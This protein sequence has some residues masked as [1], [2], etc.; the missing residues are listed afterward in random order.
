MYDKSRG[1]WALSNTN[2]DKMAEMSIEFKKQFKDPI[3]DYIEINSNIVSQIIDTPAFQRLKDIRQTS[4][5]PLFPA[6]HHNRYVHSLGVYHLGRMAFQA[7]EA[8]LAEYSKNT[9]LSSK[10]ESIKKTFELACLLHDIGHAPFSHTGEKFYL[11][12]AETLYA[13]LKE[14]VGDD[15]FSKDFDALGVNKPAPHECMSCVV[16]LRTYSVFFENVEQKAFFAR[17]II[18]MKIRLTEKEPQEFKQ[19]MDEGERKALKKQRELYAARKREVELL[20]CVIS[21]LNSSIIDVDRLDYIIRDSATIGFKNAQ[22]DYKRLLDGMRIV[23]Y[24]KPMERGK[25][26]KNRKELCVGYHKSALSVLESAIYAHDAEKKWIQGH[27]SILYEMAALQN[28]MGVL[29]QQFCTK[30][31]SNPIFCYE[32]LTENGKELLSLV[33]LFSDEAKELYSRKEMFSPAAQVLFGQGKLF[34]KESDIDIASL[35]I[36]KKFQLNLLADEDFLYLMKSFCKNGLGYE[37]FARN[38]R[39]FPAWKSEAEFRA[40]FQERIGDD[41]KNI[42]ILEDNF[43]GLADFCMAKT[44]VSIV[45]EK[46]FYLLDEEEHENNYS[47]ENE[48]IDVDYYEDIARRIA[49]N[50]YWARELKQI[51]IDLELHFEFLIIFQRK[52]NSSFKSSVGDIPIL[53]PNLDNQVIP[54][55]NIVDVLKSSADKKSNFFHIF[56][57]P[58]RSNIKSKKEIINKIAKNL[59]NAAN[60]QSI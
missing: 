29:T 7:I 45:D 48:E 41:S 37:Y 35:M 60:N 36:V 58:K 55:Q 20:N 47:R 22:V 9:N 39:R 6:A 31:D 18:G 44:G 3:Y 28:A 16:G 27:P 59:I 21:L 50:R 2:E 49:E 38:K 10:M 56:Y 14:Y 17:C 5:T 32:A 11:D 24:E 57:R 33:P 1:D 52:F 34:S 46:I 53:F 43:E 54:L 23:L 40:L 13:T 51:A 8:Q 26:K 19:N 42:K 25:Q 12:E 30:E 4:Y 15:S